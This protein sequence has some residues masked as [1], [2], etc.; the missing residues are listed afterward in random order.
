MSAFEQIQSSAEDAILELE[1]EIIDLEEKIEAY[2]L[3]IQSA[4]IQIQALK[5]FLSPDENSSVLN[6]GNLHDIVLQTISDFRE[7]SVHYKDLT[8][9]IAQNGYEISGKQ[10]EKTVLNCLMKLAKAG[11]IKNAGKGYYKSMIEEGQAL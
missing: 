2:K 5:K 9:I 3:R 7:Q 6:D 8:D 11:T 1:S 4:K 10:P